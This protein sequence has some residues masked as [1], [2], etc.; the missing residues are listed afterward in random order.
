MNSRKLLVST[1]NELRN[2]FEEI[3]V[4]VKGQGSGVRGQ[5]SRVKS[6]GLGSR[7]KGQGSRVKGQKLGSRVRVR[8][9]FPWTYRCSN[10][11]HASMGVCVWDKLRL[12]YKYKCRINC[13]ASVM[14]VG[15]CL[16]EFL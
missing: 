8:A 9:P 4:S 13:D 7:V 1:G 11:V 6:Q 10:C 2:I 16:G 14:C 3:C 5:G 15:T 12:G